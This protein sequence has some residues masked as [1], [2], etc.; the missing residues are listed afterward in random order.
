MKIF[1]DVD[2]VIADFSSELC[3][4]LDIEYDASAA[5]EDYWWIEK[6]A[7]RGRIYKAMRGEEFWRSLKPYPW[8][9]DLVKLVNELTDGNWR[10]LTKATTDGG[11]HSGKYEWI[12]ENFGR[13]LNRLTICQGPKEF[14]AHNGVILVDDKK[15][16]I[17]EFEKEGGYG[18]HWVEV[19]PQGDVSKHF[20]ELT[21]YYR[22]ARDGVSY[23]KDKD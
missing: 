9:K 19:G 10:F 7:P 22:N 1:L 6:L 13:D 11:C 2:G 4:K 14:Y 8:A 3:K 20:K 21:Q 15:E 17:L 18:Y 16:A 12:R 23:E 5:H